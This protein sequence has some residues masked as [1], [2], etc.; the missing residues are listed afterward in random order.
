MERSELEENILR[1]GLDPKNKKSIHI[2]KR[3]GC[4]VLRR[5]KSKKKEEEETI[6]VGQLEVFFH[7]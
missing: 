5:D 1:I 4:G 3:W 6:S 7:S 2:N